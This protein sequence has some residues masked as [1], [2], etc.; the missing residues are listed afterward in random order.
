MNITKL[1]ESFGL[2]ETEVQVY[3]HTLERESWSAQD[4]ARETALKRPTVYHALETLQKKGLV[5]FV[6]HK[7]T[8]HFKAESPEQLGAL[9]RREKSR[10]I[11]LE[12][13]LD[14]ALPLFPTPTGV[15]NVSSE[16]T[17]YRGLEGL[18]N[19]SEKSY[20]S[21]SKVLYSIMPSFR[22]IEQNVD[23]AYMTHYLEERAKRGIV[24]K[25]IWQDLPQNKEFLKHK[26]FLRTVRLAPKSLCGKSNAMIDIF[27]NHVV[28]AMPLPEVFGFMVTSFEYS[29]L[30]RAMWQTLWDVSTPLSGRIKI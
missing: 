20:V 25:S 5:Y 28:T 4:L 15:I 21:K 30:M 8:G 3:L 11:D 2:T 1:L 12:K 27:D 7:R 23:E 9:L 17:Y 22:V 26:K 10:I 14:K 16:V 24:T 29:E 19:L 18:K 6:G 13:K